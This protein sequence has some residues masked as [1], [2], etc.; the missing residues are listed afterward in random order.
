MKVSSVNCKLVLKLW[1]TESNIHTS[2]LSSDE[3]T[4]EE[5]ELTE[6]LREIEEN[7]NK[8]ASI[9][10]VRAAAEEINSKRHVKDTSITDFRAVAEGSK[11]KRHGEAIVP[12]EVADELLRI[13]ESDDSNNESSLGGL[14]SKDGEVDVH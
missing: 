8:R 11:L 14:D 1:S 3:Q 9:T 2:F 4:E 12:V 7:K 6:P 10:D 5:F 13:N